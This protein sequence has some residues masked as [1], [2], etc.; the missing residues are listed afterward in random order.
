[1]IERIA[2]LLRGLNSQQE[3]IANLGL[4]NKIVEMRW[5]QTIVKRCVALVKRL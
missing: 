3:T 4:S 1:M 2:P 5:S